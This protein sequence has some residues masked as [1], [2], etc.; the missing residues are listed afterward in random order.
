[1][2]HPPDSLFFSLGQYLA[3]SSQSSFEL[4]RLEEPCLRLIELASCMK[5]SSQ[6][7]QLQPTL[8]LCIA[9]KSL[10][11]ASLKLLLQRET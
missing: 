4:Y 7:S 9:V 10:H 11:I 2:L 6:R 5:V 8:S 1:M 3:Q